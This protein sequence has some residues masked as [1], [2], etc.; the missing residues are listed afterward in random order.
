M[1]DV[2]KQKYFFSDRTGYRSSMKKKAANRCSPLFSSS[3]GVLQP[4]QSGTSVP[5]TPTP[6]RILPL[7][8]VS[9]C[10]RTIHG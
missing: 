5:G 9:V 6:T 3:V 4:P 2:L 7:Q 1:K 10:S 8:V